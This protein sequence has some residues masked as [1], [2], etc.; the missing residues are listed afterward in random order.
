VLDR[1][2]YASAEG[3]QSADG[4]PDM[5]PI[6][7]GLEVHVASD[8]GQQLAEEGVKVRVVSVPSWELFD[9]QS[10]DYRESVLPS[11]VRARMA[12]EAGLKRG[13]DH[14]VGSDGAVVGTQS[15]GASAHAGVLYEKF[16]IAARNVAAQ[17]R[18]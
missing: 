9:R 6:G 2:V 1:L 4:T 3:L 17:A 5:I 10:A 11:A 8:A 16:G 12:A 7:T 13:W 18:S 14:Y 15:F